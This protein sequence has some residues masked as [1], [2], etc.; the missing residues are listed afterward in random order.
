VLLTDYAWP[1]DAIERRIVE[2]AGYALHS[3][4]PEPA[5]PAQIEK[6]ARELRPAAILTCWARVSAE[7]IDAAPELA[8]VAR[9]GVG[10]DNI[11]VEHAT[12]RGVLV[13]N[14]PDYCVEEVS[15]HAVGMLL[16]WARGLV[17]FDRSVK[18][19]RWE[20]ASARLRRVQDLTVGLYGYGRIGRRSAEKLAAFGVRLLACDPAYS[21][22]ALARAVSERELLAASDVVIVHAPLVASTQHAFAAERL[23]Q[24]RPGA[25]L[26][27]VSRGPI[28][29]NDALLAA[30][31]SG[32]LSGAG[33][34]VIEGEPEPP[35]ALVL[36]PDVIVTPHVAF[37][38][39]ASL[40]ELRTRA[41]EE[42][43]RVLRGEAPQHPCNRP[44]PDRA[45]GMS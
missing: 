45:K 18:S 32:Q 39:S 23:A 41:A 30:L 35:R 2:S 7:A 16:A 38:S 22:G 10:L 25:F 4:P 40:A 14:V 27:N 31:A 5:P 11:D 34:D 19:G 24:M 20:P 15:D 17:H 28:V 12:A 8:I 43:V 44:R 37:S 6:L 42:V 1:D 3:G 29:D 33:L 26:I 36:R 21:G 9:L 13:T